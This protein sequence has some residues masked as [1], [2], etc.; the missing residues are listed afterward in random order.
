MSVKCICRCCGK[1]FLAR[2]YRNKYCST[3][4][5]GTGY[6]HKQKKKENIPTRV[7]VTIDDVV[8]ESIRLSKER[9]RY[10]SY[11]DVQ[12]E[13]LTGKLTLKGGAAE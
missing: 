7:S 2:D 6:I 9:G 11:G 8:A 3:E 4:C 13:L 1:E 5:R 10:V 12:K